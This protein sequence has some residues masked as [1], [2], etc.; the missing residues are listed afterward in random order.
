MVE[1]WAA[2]CA[3][4]EHEPREEANLASFYRNL[5]HGEGR[6]PGRLLRAAGNLARRGTRRAGCCGNYGEPGC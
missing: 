1:L 6:L 5:A 3:G 4:H 2:I